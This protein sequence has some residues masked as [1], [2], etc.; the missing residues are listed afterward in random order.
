[1]HRI[2]SFSFPSNFPY[3]SQR[4]PRGGLT[5]PALTQAVPTIDAGRPQRLGKEMTPPGVSKKP[6]LLAE[7]TPRALEANRKSSC[8]KR[9]SE[10]RSPGSYPGLANGCHR[11][12]LKLRGHSTVERAPSKEH[13]LESTAAGSVASAQPLTFPAHTFRLEVGRLE[14]ASLENGRLE[15]GQLAPS[16]A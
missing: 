8:R 16:R 6:S 12:P 14:P 7:N 9:R 11:R 10:G 3:V 1:M 13:Y 2:D 15:T 5:S 4:L